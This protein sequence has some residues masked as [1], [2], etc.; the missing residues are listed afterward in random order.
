MKQET[1]KISKQSKGRKLSDWITAFDGVNKKGQKTT[2]VKV[3]GNESYAQEQ[4]AK[5]LGLSPNEVIISRA[6]W[7]CNASDSLQK[8]LSLDILTMNDTYTGNV[9]CHSEFGDVYDE[10]TGT[11][12]AQAKA[13]K[14]MREAAASRFKRWQIKMLKKLYIVSPETFVKAVDE[15]MVDIEVSQAAAERSKKKATTAKKPKTTATAKKTTSKAKTTT[16]TTA[17]KAKTTAK[18]KKDAIK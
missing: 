15:A 10:T 4:L 13:F 7:D 16:K 6:N 3:T 8:V 5:R 9:T 14:N 2:T 12:L 17:T 1:Q 11:N 18:A